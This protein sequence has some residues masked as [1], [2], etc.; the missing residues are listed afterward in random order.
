MPPKRGDSR[1]M[2][3]RWRSTDFSEVVAQEHVTRTLK[4][5]VAGGRIVHAYLFCGPRG[6]GKTS[7]AR[8]LAKAVNCHSPEAGEPCNRCPSCLMVN[9]GR[10]IDLIEIDAAS[11]RGI[12]DARELREKIRFSPAEARYKVYIIDEAHMLTSEAANALLKTL[13]EPP[14]HAILILATTESHKILPTIASRCQRFDFRRIPLQSIIDR[15]SL[16]C[17]E[18]GIQAGEGVLDRVAR[19]AR[20]S[21]RDAESLLD[22]LVAYCGQEINLATARDVLGLAGEELIPEF[23]EAVRRADLARGLQLIDEAATS[24]ADLRHFSR[25]M[26]EYLRALTITKSGADTSLVRELRPDALTLLRT[27]ASGWD[28]VQLAAALKA[29]G[30]MEGRMRLEPFNQSHLELAL[31]E[32]ALA[33][34][35]AGVSAAVARERV[36]TPAPAPRTLAAEQVELSGDGGPPAGPVSAPVE[37]APAPVESAAAVPMEEAPPDPELAPSETGDSLDLEA[38]SAR[39][40]GILR[41]ISSEASA[42]GIVL[43]GGEP[44]EVSGETVVFGFEKNLWRQKAEQQP[45]VRNM[46]EDSLSKAFGA[47]VQVQFRSGGRPD[48]GRPAGKQDA[49][50]DVAV[51]EL[52]FEVVRGESTGAD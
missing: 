47:K 31:L 32:V 29:F 25:E 19:M 6:T 13:E 42:V 36:V 8:I 12:D 24:G 48:T 7:T 22:Q 4:N 15:L 21:L 3:Q 44:V 40:P 41:D 16:I 51:R 18:E 49:V 43:R 17:R 1:A 10:A 5:A 23:A 9:E 38:V 26:V 27:T 14:E 11:N 20:G 37:P 35:A 50:V 45:R 34:G 28:Y 39:W 2:Y 33:E 52:G 46:L 30:E